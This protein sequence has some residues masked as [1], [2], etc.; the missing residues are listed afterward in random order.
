M[1]GNS[2][3]LPAGLALARSSASTDLLG[4]LKLRQIIFAIMG[5]SRLKAFGFGTHAASFR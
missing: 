3:N 5:P 1:I 4:K 2:M